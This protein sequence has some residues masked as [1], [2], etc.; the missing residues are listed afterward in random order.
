MA[1]GQSAR[2][3][4]VRLLDQETFDPILRATRDP[5]SA[6]RNLGKGP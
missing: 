6:G 2:D 1:A 5:H 3:K 4:L